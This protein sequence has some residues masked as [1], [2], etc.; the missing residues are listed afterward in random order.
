MPIPEDL[1]VTSEARP[2]VKDSTLGIPVTPAPGD[3]IPKHRLV[4]I[5]DSLTHGFKSL[6]VH[7]THLSYPAMLAHELGW[8]K[9]FRF[10]IYGGP[11]GLPLDLEWLLRGLE[12][13][14]GDELDLFESVGA[15]LTARRLLEDNED[16]WERGAGARIPKQPGIN[17]NLAIYGWDLRDTLSRDADVLRRAMRPAH[18][19]LWPSMPQNSS[20]LAGLY[21]LDSARDIAGNALTPLEAAAQLGTEG[22]ET[23]IVFIGANNAL[24]TVLTLDVVWSDKDYADPEKKRKYTVWRPEH[25][26]AELKEVVAAVRRIAA[27]HVLWL[28]IPHVTIAPLAHGVGDK[29]DES[30]RYFSFYT[31]PWVRD[32]AFQE[33]PTRY[34]SLTGVEARQIDSAIDQYNQAIIDSVEAARREGRDW[35]IVDIAAVLDGLAERRY[36]ENPKAR[37]KWWKEYKL[38]PEIQKTLG[39]RPTTRFLN[40]GAGKVTQGG[41]VALDGVH[42][43]TTGYSIIAHECMKVMVD[44]GVQFFD[45]N[46]QARPK[47]KFNFKRVIEADTLLTNPLRSLGSDLNLLGSLDDRFALIAGAE[48]A[49][50]RRKLL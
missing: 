38:P 26:A 1:E 42:P 9:E 41:L 33:K 32:D 18:D 45:E 40:S 24:A 2:P 28:T 21:V 16:F 22:I 11:G 25:F 10:P 15:L 8:S 23:L 31:R 5:G 44:A 49:F 48:R 36:L 6:A 12:R 37:P 7:E 14:F 35:R 34:P 19:D 43:T 46:G 50:R 29:L 3:G 13:K 30:S 39:F 20:S 4:A 27:R 17:H 47:P